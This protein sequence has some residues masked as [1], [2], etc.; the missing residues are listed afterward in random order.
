M[1]YIRKLPSGSYRAEVARAG[2]RI[3]KVFPTKM[4][5]KDWAARQEYLIAEQGEEVPSGTFGDLLDRYSREVSDKKRGS[6]WE[7]IRIEKIRKD[8]LAQ[9]QLAALKASDLADWRDRRLAEV[10]PASVNRE[11][12]ILSAALNVARKEWGL[13]KSNPMED[14][15]RPAA[16]PPRDRL[17]TADEMDRLQHAAGTDLQYAT[18]RAYHAFLFAV[19]TAMRAGEIVGLTSDRIDTKQRV[20]KL[21]QT[22]NGRPRDVPLSSEAIRLLEDLPKADPVF[23]LTSQ[24]LDV[25]WRKVRV[26]AVV[27][28]LTFH[29]SRHMAIT[30]LSK[31]LDVLAL[32]RM[33]GHTNI[34]M[35]TV[36]YNESAE[37]LAKRLD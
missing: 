30:R 33:V 3:S 10:A 9:V 14:V 18:A 13:I 7:T 16:P 23:G 29:D 35:L 12:H 25:L 17:A 37:E 5:A 1:A 11:M 36:Y 2:K 20:V 28:G 6:R 26:K 21:L 8:K 19:E 22:K 15:R 31:K 4:A 27:D 32:A 34:K 24:Q